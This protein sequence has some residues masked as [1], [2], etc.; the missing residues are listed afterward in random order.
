MTSKKTPSAK[1]PVPAKRVKKARLFQFKITLQGSKPPI[2]RRIQV[3]GCTLDMLHEHIQTAMGW[4]HSQLHQFMVAGKSYG[5]PEMMDDGF[6]GC[7]ALHS[8]RT[9]HRASV[10]KWANQ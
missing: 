7:E 10:R 8:T 5:D 6:D 2:W 4:T 1:K 3:E 9:K